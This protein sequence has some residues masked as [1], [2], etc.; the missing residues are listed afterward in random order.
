M[1]GAGLVRGAGMDRSLIPWAARRPLYALLGTFQILAA[2]SLAPLAV[3]SPGS[4]GDL[5]DGLTA[6]GWLALAVVN[7]VPRLRPEWATFEICLYAASGLAIVQALVSARPQSPMLTGIE[8]LA[9]SL[10]GVFCLTGRQLYRWLTVT[11]AGFVLAAGWQAVDDAAA[12]LIGVVL[13]ALTA[14]TVRQLVQQVVHASEHDPLTGALN[15]L[16]LRDRAELVRSYAHRRGEPTTV[17]VLD[18]DHFK[19]YN[20]RL[21][22]AAGDRLL[23]DVVARLQ[24]ALRRSD[25]VARSG[26]DEFVLVLVG[27]DE[28]RARAVLQRVLP[29][30]PVYC[31]HG[32]APWL[33]ETEL[34][35]AI[36]AA[37]RAMYARRRES[38]GDT[39]DV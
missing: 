20:D 36:D 35:E 30:L 15:R 17:A 39:V 24:A 34:A 1:L 28:A 18:I 21:G 29:D 38:R 14:L 11:G 37:D 4:R 23:I 26:G 2:V 7:L 32:T 6:I 22:H 10:F 8:L 9:L 3:L 16:G 27:A 31:S 5:V 13:I 33:P 12:A 19:A 25:L